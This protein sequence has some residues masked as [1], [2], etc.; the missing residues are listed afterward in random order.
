MLY[1]NM[2]KAEYTSNLKV[3]RNEMDFMRVGIWQITNWRD[4][5]FKMS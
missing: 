4:S 2:L 3:K 1:E 5:N